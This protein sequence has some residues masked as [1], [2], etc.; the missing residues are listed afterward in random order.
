MRK[1]IFLVILILLSGCAKNTQ[2]D[3]NTT[4]MG[5]TVVCNNTGCLEDEW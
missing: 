2:C 1:V 3:C 4:K 5:T